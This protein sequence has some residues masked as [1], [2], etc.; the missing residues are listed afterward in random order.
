MSPIDLGRTRKPTFEAL[1]TFNSG[2]LHGRG[3]LAQGCIGDGVYA[4][5]RTVNFKSGVYPLCDL[6]RLIH[7][8]SE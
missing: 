3:C 6:V 1:N 5:C 8:S 4:V 2:N 7:S